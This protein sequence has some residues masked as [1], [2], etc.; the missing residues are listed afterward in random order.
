MS[1]SRDAAGISFGPE[2]VVTSSLDRISCGKDPE[3]DRH[4]SVNASLQG[5][6]FV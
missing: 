3:W 1:F 6:I 4:G 2:S 5:R